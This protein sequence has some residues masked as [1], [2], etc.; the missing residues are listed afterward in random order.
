MTYKITFYGL[1]DKDII[2]SA[3]GEL[4][5]LISRNF[6]KADSF[7]L[8]IPGTKKLYI[9]NPKNFQHIS[10]DEEENENDK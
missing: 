5:E 2:I 3:N 9:L 7:P 10:I 1:T 8:T 4:T 6:F